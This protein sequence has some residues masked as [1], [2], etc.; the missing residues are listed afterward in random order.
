MSSAVNH[1]KRS[2]RSE[3]LKASAFNASSRAAY[4]RTANSPR[5]NSVFGRVASLFHRRAMKAA[6]PK[7]ADNV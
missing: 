4:Y 7:E 5:S 2:H 6:P 3:H 1:R